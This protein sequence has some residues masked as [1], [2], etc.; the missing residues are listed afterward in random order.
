MGGDEER[1]GRE[2]GASAG[3]VGIERWCLM[4]VE[5]LR[6]DVEGEMLESMLMK[7]RRKSFLLEKS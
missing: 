7:R 1:V 6:T 4:G 5:R 2:N 3:R